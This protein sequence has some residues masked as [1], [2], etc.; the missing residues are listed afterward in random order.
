MIDRIEDTLRR[1][2]SD[3]SAAVRDAANASLDRIRAKRLKAACLEK[4]RS[5]TLE[6]RVRVVFTAEDMG[7]GEGLAVLL[8]ALSDGAAEVRGAAVRALEGFLTPPVLQTMVG[9]LPR[10]KGVVLGNLLE[11]LGKSR[12]KE[13]CPI[14][15]KYMEHPDT[16]V[17]GRAIVAYGRV[18]AGGWEKIISLASSPEGAVR[19]AVALSLGEWTG[20]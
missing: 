3:P 5:G 17:R 1:M 11:A 7:G 8:A 20:S 2:L 10:E 13:L 18:S 19:A 12:R 16:E 15:E 6:E 9:M 14:I 4:L